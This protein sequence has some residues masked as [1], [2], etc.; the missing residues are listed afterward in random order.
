MTA[1]SYSAQHSEPARIIELGDTQTSYALAP[2]IRE[3]TELQAGIA[4]LRGGLQLQVR[5]LDAIEMRLS[6]MAPAGRIAAH[7]LV[8]LRET[9]RL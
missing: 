9:G 4:R 8:A 5:Q 7:R 1:A 3:T 6:P 2:F